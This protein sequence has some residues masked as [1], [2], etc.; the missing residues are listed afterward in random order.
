VIS[1]LKGAHFDKYRNSW[2][3]AIRV[4]GKNINLGRYPTAQLAHESYMKAA[5]LH[6]GEFACH[7]R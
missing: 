2:K 5:A 7:E 4:E 1:G 6:Y 3:S